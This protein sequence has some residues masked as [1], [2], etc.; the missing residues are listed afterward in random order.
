MPSVPSTETAGLRAQFAGDQLEQRGLAD[1]VAADE[2]GAL[3]AETQVEIGKER[4]AVRRGPR[5][6]RD[7]VMEAGMDVPRGKAIGIAVGLKSIAA[8]S[9]RNRRLSGAGA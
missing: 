2:P 6:D 1:A 3:G 8:T 4:P 5:R 9:C 7:S